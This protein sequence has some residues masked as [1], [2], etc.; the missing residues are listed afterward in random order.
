MAQNSKI[1]V[2]LPCYKS[3]AQVLDVLQR[4]PPHV[5]KIYCVDDACPEKTGEHIKKNSTDKRIKILNHKENQ[6][7]GGALITGYKQALADKMDVIVK[8]D[9]DGQMDPEILP[10]FVKPILSGQADYT[11]GNRF[12]TPE[13]L[14]GMPMVRLL[15]NAGLSF[16]NKFSSGYWQVMDPT[17]GYTAI[18]ASV[19]RLLPLDKINKGY[20]FESDMLFRLGTLRAVVMDVPQKAIYGEEKSNLRVSNA[21]W[22]FALYH[23]RNFFKRIVYNYFVRDF[24]VASLEWILGPVLFFFSLIFGISSWVE[25]VQ[26]ETSASAGTVMLAALPFLAGLQLIL[27]ALHFD[28]QNQ[29]KTPIQ[30][31][32]DEGDAL[33]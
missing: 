18:H 15:G 22:T 5:S 4:I 1:A 25:A 14:E 8:I 21:F 10:G 17:N 3:S 32:M 29:P 19:L 13:F 6:G 12:Y 27:S 31:L 33:S 16:M 26:N 11:K 20:F 7:V 30:S 23:C 2:I 24:N 28:V 9:S